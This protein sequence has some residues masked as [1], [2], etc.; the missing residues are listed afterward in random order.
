MPLND[1]VGKHDDERLLPVGQNLVVR[2]A[3]SRFEAI[4]CAL[5]HDEQCTARAAEVAPA[6]EAIKSLI[7]TL[8]DYIRS[9][10]QQNTKSSD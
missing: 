8:E 3:L 7:A 10:M 5:N 2:I 9:Q 1:G 4:L 6:G